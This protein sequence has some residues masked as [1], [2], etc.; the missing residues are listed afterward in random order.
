MATILSIS[1]DLNLLKTRELL[2]S[3]MGYSVISA[4]GFAQAFKAC[5][6]KQFD[7]VILGHSIPADDKE[8]IIREVRATRTCPVL[9]LLRQSEQHVP[10]AERSVSVFEPHQ[11]IEAV[12]ELVPASH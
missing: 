5:K 8:A 2:L 7:L 10:H 1:Y 9:A 12:K 11:F 4:E 6:E 3:Q